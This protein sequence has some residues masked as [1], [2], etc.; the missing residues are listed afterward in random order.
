MVLNYGIRP[1][2]VSLGIA[3]AALSAASALLLALLLQTAGALLLHGV[4][5]PLPKWE[6]LALLRLQHD[7][8][9]A[10]VPR[11]LTLVRSTSA[12]GR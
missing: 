9:C 3:V 12:M 10:A 5:V 4:F 6:P 2:G 11:L 8:L 1:G 7:A